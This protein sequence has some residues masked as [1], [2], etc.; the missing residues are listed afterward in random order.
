MGRKLT[1]GGLLRYRKWVPKQ[2]GDVIVVTNS[3]PIGLMRSQLTNHQAGIVLAV[4]CGHRYENLFGI[5]VPIIPWLKVWKNKEH[6]TRRVSHLSTSTCNMFYIL[7]VVRCDGVK[8]EDG[9]AQ[10]TLECPPS[11]IYPPSSIRSI[12]YFQP[13]GD[14][15][16]ET[17]N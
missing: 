6:S 3:P 13:R 16:S 7:S 8:S 1:D 9:P 17:G 5:P 11:I 4:H 2:L 15:W 12:F 10:C 14:R